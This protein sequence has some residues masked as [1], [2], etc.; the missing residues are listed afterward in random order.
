[1]S[2]HPPPGGALSDAALVARLA[3][4]DALALGALHDAYGDVAY[5]L[6]F[7]ITRD[8]R[9]AEDVVEE[10]FVQT[11]REARALAAERGSVPGH[12]L[13]LV[14][15]HALAA[16]RA[17][18]GRPGGLASSVL[19]AAA[20][21]PDDDWRRAAARRGLLGLPEAERRVLE[22]AY[23]GGLS[24]AELAEALAEPE[25]IVRQRLRSGL[26]RLR[27]AAPGAATTTITSETTRA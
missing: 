26:H 16:M 14:R 24:T 25:G 20:P 17:A 22:L 5:D 4:G 3:A 8:A 12:I 19:D 7:A 15:R 10:A 27:A 2:S 9:T 23:F 18:R 11:A 13:S 1:M 6:A 21:R